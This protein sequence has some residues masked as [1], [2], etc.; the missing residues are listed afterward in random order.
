MFKILSSVRITV[1]CLFLLFILTF[2]GTV[3]QAQHGLYVAQE[4]FFNSFFFL[5]GG[6]LPF[7]GA[8]LVLWV[9]FINLVCVT[10]T[11]FRT[12]RQWSQAGILTIHFGLLFYFVSAFIIFHV[13]KESNVHLMEGEGTNVSSSYNE[14]EL[15]YWSDKGQKRQV[16]AFDAKYFKPGFEI[17]FENHHF[18]ISVKQFYPNTAAFTNPNQ[19]SS[20]ILNISGISL[21]EPKPLLKEREKNIAG[22]IFD[23][24]FDGKSYA[25]VLYGAEF[26]PTPVPM[27][28]KIYYF[29][30]RHKRYPL[31][32]TLKLEQFKAQFHP[33]TNVAKSYESNVL[34]STGPLQR[35]VRIFMNNPLRYKDYT[36][37]QASYDID[38]MGRQYSTLAVVKNFARILPY[39]ACLIVFLGLALHFLIQ[40]FLLRLKQNE[41]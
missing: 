29:S 38:S 16:T 40:A 12:Y 24:K 14:W 35:Q 3:A 37:Y 30:L 1:V 27:A 31:P 15:A 2:W 9:L 26:H 34:V 23:L 18:T 20:R 41:S 32:F 28:G 19:R 33:G 21:L 5:A 8:Q 10:I 13:A 4:R 6:F 7:P 36:L 11:R 22:G 17:P 39:M 25:L